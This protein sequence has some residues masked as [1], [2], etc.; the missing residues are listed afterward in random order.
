MGPQEQAGVIMVTVGTQGRGPFQPEGSLRPMRRPCT[1][2][3]CGT[4]FHRGERCHGEPVEL[5]S[6]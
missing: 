1:G 2:G 6:W 5:H 3:C 4:P